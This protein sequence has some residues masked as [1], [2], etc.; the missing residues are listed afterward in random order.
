MIVKFIGEDGSAG[1][2]KGRYYWIK[3]M[4]EG[5]RSN[6]VWVKTPFRNAYPY[7]SM[8]LLQQHWNV[9]KIGERFRVKR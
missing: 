5:N 7:A 4:E 8:E 9:E 3:I 1:F 6:W 2:R